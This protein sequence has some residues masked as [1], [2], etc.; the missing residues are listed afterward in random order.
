MQAWIYNEISREFALTSDWDN[1]WR[2]GGNGEEICE[3]AHISPGQLLVGI[4]KFA[5]AR[6]QRIRRLREAIPV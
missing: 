3:E 1:R 5:A 4:Q 2:S 6:P